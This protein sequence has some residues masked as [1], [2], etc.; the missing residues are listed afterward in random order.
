MMPLFKLRVSLAILTHTWA[1][2]FLPG[3]QQG[4]T[5]VTLLD[6]ALCQDSK[7]A[8]PPP[9]L[10]Q[11][12][13]SQ[14]RGA[15]FS[16]QQEPMFWKLGVAVIVLVMATAHLSQ[17][18][19]LEMA[20]LGHGSSCH[21]SDVPPA[22]LP[23]CGWACKE[24]FLSWMAAPAQ[25]PEG[26]TGFKHVPC[27]FNPLQAGQ[28]PPALHHLRQHPAVL[29]SSPESLCH[30]RK[31]AEQG[32]VARGGC[33]GRTAWNWVLAPG[34]KLGHRGLSTGTDPD[35]CPECCRLHT[36]AKGGWWSRR[37]HQMGA[38]D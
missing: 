2:S 9:H 11:S 38:G 19:L 8:A 17:L 33:S 4:S 3:A 10:S 32:G 28:A 26:F 27:P 34:T 24:V 35:P 36:Q 16:A 30:P 29:P 21:T 13:E 23:A 18:S 14:I 6:T 20:I 1:S 25:Q 15:T 12:L 37:L 31:G 7:Q 22:T 5:A